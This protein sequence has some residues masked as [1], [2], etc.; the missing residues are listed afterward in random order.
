MQCCHLSGLYVHFYILVIEFCFVST[1]YNFWAEHV[2]LSD[3]ISVL[4]K[5]PIKLLQLKNKINRP[6]KPFHS[7]IWT[8]LTI[9]NLK[10]N[11]FVKYIAL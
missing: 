2:S 4:T 1:K 9:Y 3:L 8:N 5:F 10:I 11:F 6:K 7:V